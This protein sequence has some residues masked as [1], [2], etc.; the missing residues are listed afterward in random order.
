MCVG[1]RGMPAMR[2]D[3]G[4]KKATIKIC[5]LA[6]KSI[7]WSRRQAARRRAIR[8]YPGQSMPLFRHHEASRSHRCDFCIEFSLPITTY[9]QGLRCPMQSLHRPSQPISLESKDDDNSP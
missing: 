9:S 8:L 5:C 7:S 2:F 4:I 1:A 6:G 3:V